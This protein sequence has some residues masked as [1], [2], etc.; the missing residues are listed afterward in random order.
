M[1]LTLLGAG[2]RHPPAHMDGAPDCQCLSVAKTF[3][4]GAACHSYYPIN[5]AWLL[6]L[7]NYH[8][9]HY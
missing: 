3:F 6:Q 2:P 4:C 9:L 7:F 8:F 5:K 1:S